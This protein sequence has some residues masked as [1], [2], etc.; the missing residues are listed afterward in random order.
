MGWRSQTG[1]RLTPLARSAAAGFIEVATPAGF[2]PATV[3]LEVGC[4]IQLSYGANPRLN[5]KVGHLVDR[6]PQREREN[7]RSDRIRTYDPLV[8]NQMRYQAAPHSGLPV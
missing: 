3:R 6:N 1:T 4:S 5:T 2:E 8:P 7:G